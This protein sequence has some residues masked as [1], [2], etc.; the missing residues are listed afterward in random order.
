LLDYSEGE[1]QAL[2]AMFAREIGRAAATNDMRCLGSAEALWNETIDDMIHLTNGEE[3]LN[4]HT[5][6]VQYGAIEV[7]RSGPTVGLLLRNHVERCA[8][9]LDAE[10]TRR[11]AVALLAAAEAMVQEQRVTADFSLLAVNACNGQTDAA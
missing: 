3:M 9:D 1:L 10:E 7:H 8:V 11:V 6:N 2:N 5:E 4:S